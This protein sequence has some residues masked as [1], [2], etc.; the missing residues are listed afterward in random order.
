[1]YRKLN[2][3]MNKQLKKKKKVGLVTNF[4]KFSNDVKYID[5]II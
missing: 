4:L 2:N 5:D 1:M 3:S